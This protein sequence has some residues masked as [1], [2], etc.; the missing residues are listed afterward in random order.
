MTRIATITAICIICLCGAAAADDTALLDIG[1]TIQPMDEHPTV[2]LVAEHVHA[3]IFREYTLVECVFFLEN[4]GPATEVTVGFPN[5]VYGSDEWT[6]LFESFESYVD[7]KRADIRLVEQP[8]GKPC[9]WYCKEVRFDEGELRTIRNVYRGRHSFDTMNDFWFTYVLHTGASWRGAIG[10]VSVVLSFEEFDTG[11]LWRIEPAGGEIDGREIRWSFTDYEP[12]AVR[13]VIEVKWTGLFAGDIKSDIHR[14]AALGDIDGVRRLLAEGADIDAT[15]G[16]TQTPLV[17]AIYYGAGPEMVS[18]LLENGATV[19]FDHDRGLYISPLSTAVLA[20]E[21]YAY[22]Q[23]LEI[24]RLL[25][26]HGAPVD[27]VPP[28]AIERLPGD[29]RG[30]L[31]ERSGD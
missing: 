9:V 22:P 21:R 14:A 16:I 5:N 18:F 26:E 15:R 17:D 2:R 1:G 20:Y 4:D 25:V 10:S 12:N 19:A 11:R 13:D 31:R 23:T 28:R 7:G 30:F 24:L 27:A 8:E 3:R 29:L 6:C